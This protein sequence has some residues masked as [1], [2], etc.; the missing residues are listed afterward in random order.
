[1]R[2]VRFTRCFVVDEVAED[3]KYASIESRSCLD[4]SLPEKLWPLHEMLRLKRSAS[5]C[6][7]SDKTRERTTC[8]PQKYQHVSLC[9]QYRQ[10]AFCREH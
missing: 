1:M 5:A 6:A 9:L 7:M 8:S 10:S 4:A 3:E 2:F